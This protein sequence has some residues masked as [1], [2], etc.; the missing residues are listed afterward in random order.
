MG[1][2]LW[3]PENDDLC[4]DLWNFGRSMSQVG[5]VLGVSRSAIAGRLKRLRQAGRQ[6]RDGNVGQHNK[7]Q[8]IAGRQ[9]AALRPPANKPIVVKATAEPPM[10]LPIYE[11]GDR[12][13]HYPCATE[14]GVHLFC[15]HPARLKSDYC[16]HHHKVVWLPKH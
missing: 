10:L 2:V 4:I 11:L 15:G 12:D 6:I 13:C 16:D 8:R 5:D 14:G 7:E 1:K 9:R 3:T